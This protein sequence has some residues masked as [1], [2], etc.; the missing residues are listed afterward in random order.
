MN[1]NTPNAITLS[2]IALTP[3]FLLVLLWSP[4]GA[5]WSPWQ[6]V[7]AAAL[8][9][10]TAGT[11]G[12]DGY[13]AR[14]R[15]LVTNLGKILD[16]LADKL[17]VSAA[18]I[19]LVGLGQAPAWV[20]WLILAREFAVTGLRAIAASASGAVIAASWLGKVKTVTQMAAVLALLLEARLPLM[21]GVT[22][23]L[24][25]LYLA[26]AMTIWSGADYIYQARDCLK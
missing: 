24:P 20:V 10:I 25:L 17:L 6:D 16:P 2:R 18:L 22:P 23:G 13:I 15:G 12:L 14:S 1:M 7:W 26:L 8:F 5:P 19:A 21:A 9:L 3:V 4:G 11:D